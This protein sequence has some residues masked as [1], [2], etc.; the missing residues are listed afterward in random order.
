VTDAAV[1]DAIS[2][3]QRLRNE[4]ATDMQN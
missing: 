4:L 3:M 1:A 2:P